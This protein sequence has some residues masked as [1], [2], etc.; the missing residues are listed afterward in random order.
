MTDNTIATA[1]RVFEE[2][3]HAVQAEYVPDKPVVLE[4]TLGTLCIA[5]YQVFPDGRVIRLT[6]EDPGNG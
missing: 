4:C 5:R 6:E 1:R 2:T 3:L